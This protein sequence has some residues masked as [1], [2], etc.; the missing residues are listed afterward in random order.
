VYSYD[1]FDGDLCLN[2]FDIG[3]TPSYVFEVLK[4]IQSVNSS[5]DTRLNANGTI[6]SDSLID[7]APRACGSLVPG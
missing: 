4:D 7:S 1:D 5:E 3:Y 2:D 6:V